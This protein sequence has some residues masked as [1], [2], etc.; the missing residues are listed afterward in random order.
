[1]VPPSPESAAV[2]AQIVRLQSDLAQKMLRMEAIREQQ[3][4]DLINSAQAQHSTAR[5][6][7]LA[8]GVGQNLDI[9]V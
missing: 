7:N 1:M 6:A 3:I 2:N 4:F 9:S 8:S 5:L